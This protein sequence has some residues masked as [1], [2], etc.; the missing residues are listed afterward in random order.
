PKVPIGAVTLSAIDPRTH[1]T[2]GRATGTLTVGNPFQATIVLRGTGALSGKVL[3]FSGDPEPNILPYIQNTFLQTRTDGSGSFRLEGVPVGDLSQA[4]EAVD[5]KEEGK[6]VSTSFRLWNEGEEAR[7]TLLF[8]DSRRGGIAGK[9][10]RANGSIASGVDV[11]LADGNYL[12]KGQKRTGN[13]GSFSFSDLPPGHYTLA[14]TLGN[15]GGSE[16]VS[17]Q[18]PGHYITKDIHFLGLGKVRIHVMAADGQSGVM[19][20]VRVVYPIIEVKEGDHVGLSSL[21]L[22]T[23]TDVNGNLTLEKILVGN[24]NVEAFNA[25]YPFPVAQS[26]RI[27]SPG[28]EAVFDLVMKPTGKIQGKVLSPGG[29]N[30]VSGA[31][32]C[33]KA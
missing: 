12:I 26:R 11:V 24:V 23:S 1:R 19:A 27:P 18:F 2:G 5:E 28:G 14:S 31:K 9:V 8:P 20:N 25:F 10:Y 7:V 6:R 29:G 13:D 4:V 15:D 30:P 22:N 33:L 32:V 3:S 21:E 16:K 17:V